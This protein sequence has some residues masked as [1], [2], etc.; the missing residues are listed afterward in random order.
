LWIS[1]SSFYTSNLSSMFLLCSVTMWGRFFKSLP[2]LH[3]PCPSDP[4]LFPVPLWPFLIWNIIHI[5]C[6]HFL[7]FWSKLS[8]LIQFC[9]H[10]SSERA[11]LKATTSPH[12]TRGNRHFPVPVLSARH[13]LLESRVSGLPQ[14]TGVPPL[15]VFFVSSLPALSDF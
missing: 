3:T 11:I 2:H 4:V 7:I 5:N 9:P 14:S 10:S 12:V 8:N 1:L 6:L 15:M 13:S